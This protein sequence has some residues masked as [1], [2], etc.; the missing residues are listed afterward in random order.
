MD[1]ILLESLLDT[2]SP[3][4]PS[5]WTGPMQR[6]QSE[7]TEADKVHKSHE[8]SVEWYLSLG[9]VHGNSRC[10]LMCQSACYSHWYVVTQ[11]LGHS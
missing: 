11:P 10:G 4:I 2:V 7:Q 5:D 6:A 8:A 9:T 3:Y 1:C